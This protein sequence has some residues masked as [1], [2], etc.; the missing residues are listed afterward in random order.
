M[1]LLLEALGSIVRFLLAGLMGYLVGHGVFT[2]TQ[3]DS[4]TAALAGAIAAGILSLGWSLWQKYSSRIKL[5]TALSLPAGSSIEQVQQK[6]DSGTGAKLG[7]VLL[8][9]ALGLGAPLALTGCAGKTA[10]VVSPSAQT[11]KILSAVQKIG[12]VVAAVQTQEA[13]LYANGQI[14]ADV[15]AKAV[16]AFKDTSAAVLVA[17]DELQRVPGADPHTVVKAVSDG[18]KTLAAT[19]AHLNAKQADQLAGWLDTAAALIDLALA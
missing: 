2:Q 11:A 10:P 6:V 12:T 3:A 1:P 4:Y 9:A 5:L 16:T 18:V 14:P 13:Q 8:A 15:H 7:I 17:L 19:F